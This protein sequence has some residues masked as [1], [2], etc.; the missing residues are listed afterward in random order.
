MG[1]VNEYLCF[2]FQYSEIKFKAEAIIF[3]IIFSL[4]SRINK[5]SWHIIRIYTGIILESYFA[6][7]DTIFISLK[8]AVWTNYYFHFA[9]IG[10]LT[11]FFIFLL[12]YDTLHQRAI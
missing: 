11:P 5:A 12:Q 7:S 2:L 6:V 4:P 3:I 8:Q 10:I 1:M 9:E